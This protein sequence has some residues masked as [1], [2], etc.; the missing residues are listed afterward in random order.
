MVARSMDPVYQ[1]TRLFE[2]R[3]K[4]FANPSIVQSSKLQVEYL[5]AGFKKLVTEV[6]ELDIFVL[7]LISNRPT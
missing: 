5:I 2:P 4:V 1:T 3:N 6:Y 7:S